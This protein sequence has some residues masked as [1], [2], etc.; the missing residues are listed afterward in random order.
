MQIIAQNL[1]HKV[2]SEAIVLG[3]VERQQPTESTRTLRSSSRLLQ[4]GRMWPSR[5][6]K[7]KIVL[8]FN[9]ENNPAG[10]VCSGLI[11]AGDAGGALIVP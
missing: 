6:P 2:N 8:E 7:V 10:E 11:R 1:L 9:F 4:I 5:L 3:E